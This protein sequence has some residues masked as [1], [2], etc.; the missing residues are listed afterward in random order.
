M[1]SSRLASRDRRPRISARLILSTAMLAILVVSLP[2]IAQDM[3]AGEVVIEVTA[4]W[5]RALTV[6]PEQ[7]V[8]FINRSGRMVHLDFMRR[9]P[10][11]HHVFEVPDRTW[12]IFHQPGRHPYVVHFG[13]PKIS[14]LEGVIEVVRD[15]YGRPDPL[16]CGG[17]TAPGAC[18][19]R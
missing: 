6:D 5:P 1:R 18:G 8:T 17:I 14:N 12:A 13:D 16:V 4:L 2:S 19:E 15:P 10:E 9:D 11:L 7:R 3:S